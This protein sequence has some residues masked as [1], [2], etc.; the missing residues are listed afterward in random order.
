MV[1]I[2]IPPPRE[3]DEGHEGPHLIFTNMG[4]GQNPAFLCYSQVGRVDQGDGQVINL[5][6]SECLAVGVVLHETLHA[7][8]RLL[9]YLPCNDVSQGATHEMM[10][11]DRDLHVKILFENIEPGF[12]RN[13]KKKGTDLYSTRDTPFDYDSIMIYGSRDY[14]VLDSNGQRM[15]TIQPLLQGVEIR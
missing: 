10:R 13:F 5:R 1:E 14:G 3:V 15:N 8:G 7:L 6:A 4:D 2:R 12:E 11:A 9:D